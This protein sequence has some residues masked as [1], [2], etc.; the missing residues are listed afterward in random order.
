M[1]SYSKNQDN[2]W[3]KAALDEAKKASTRGD[4]GIGAVIIYKD[5][6]ISRAGNEIFSRGFTPYA[7]A[8]FNA[9]NKI[10]GTKLDSLKH[11]SQ[12]AL[13]TTV[14]PCPMCWGRMVI[15]CLAKCVF[16]DPD[17][18]V[19]QDLLK[20][21]PPFFRTYAPKVEIYKG[22]FAKQCNKMFRRNFEELDKL[23]FNQLKT[24]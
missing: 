5:K 14:A 22:K 21:L 10:R 13:Y 18:H 23:L 12:M 16:S 6:I 19:G 17:P 1:V 15:S 4:Y 2:I 24:S 7:H 8:E 3:M 20:L 9:L 11:Y